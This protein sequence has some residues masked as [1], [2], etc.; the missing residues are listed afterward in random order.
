MGVACLPVEI[1]RGFARDELARLI[2]LRRLLVRRLGLE[3]EFASPATRR[4]YAEV[5]EELL[6]P[7]LCLCLSYAS[8]RLYIYLIG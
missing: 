3:L 2:Y 7:M 8:Y 4:K 5:R 6:R 1:V